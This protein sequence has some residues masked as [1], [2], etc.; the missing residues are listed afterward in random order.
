MLGSDAKIGVPGVALLAMV[1]PV[2]TAPVCL[3][4][5]G[6]VKLL[7]ELSTAIMA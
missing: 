1:S 5:S 4:G 2:Y 7:P 6:C 3:A